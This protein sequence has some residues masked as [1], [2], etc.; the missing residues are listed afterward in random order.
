LVGIAGVGGNREKGLSLLREAAAHGTITAVES[1]TVLSLFLRHDARYAEA[2][3]IQHGLAV[4]YPHN[5]LYRLEE[6]NLTKDAGNG[7]GAIVIYKAVIADAQKPGYFIVPRLQLAY[8]GL[9]DTQRG[10]NLV[11]EATD[12]YLLA[13]Q[14]PSNTD[15]LRKRAELNAGQ[16]FDLLH[17]RAAAI[18]QYQLAAAG[19]GD[20][21]QA[22]AARK[23]L[24]T[25]YT[26]K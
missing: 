18:R 1:R 22:E 5:F 20:Q 3:V 12:N 8:F 10:Q 14:Q 25:P 16:M 6:A 15:W 9:A 26:G 17:D 19:E 2:I 7:L 24:T 23:Y 4:D 11:K 21:S 13:A